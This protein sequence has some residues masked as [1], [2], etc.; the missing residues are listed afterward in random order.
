MT[1]PTPLTRERI[2]ELKALLAM[3]TPGP[4]RYEPGGGHAYSSIRGSD[5]VQ[6]DGWR[7]NRVY[8]NRVCENLGNHE[9]PAPHANVALILALYNSASA[10][11]DAAERGMEAT[12][13]CEQIKADL[14]SCLDW[15][16]EGGDPHGHVTGR[17]VQA[18]YECTAFLSGDKENPR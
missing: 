11:L 15:I 5:S 7:S 10:L 3:A 1:D 9:L 4:W 18:I 6:I 13:T 17:I 16:R 2:K 8:S 12:K 14:E